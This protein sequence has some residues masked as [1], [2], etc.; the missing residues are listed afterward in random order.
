MTVPKRVRP[1]APDPD[2]ADA[3]NG[4]K[5]ASGGVPESGRSGRSVVICRRDALAVP[6]PQPKEFY[7]LRVVPQLRCGDGGVDRTAL[8]IYVGSGREKGR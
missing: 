8:A 4:S 7:F 2:S 1:T 6:A 5:A 3:R